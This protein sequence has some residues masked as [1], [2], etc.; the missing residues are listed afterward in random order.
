V[1]LP[2]VPPIKDSAE[3]VEKPVDTK[4]RPVVSASLGCHVVGAL[5]PH[6]DPADRETC[7]LGGKKRFLTKTPEPDDELLSELN[8]FVRKWLRE[9]LTPLASDSDTSV[10]NW[11]SH[12]NYPGWRKSQLLQKWQNVTSKFERK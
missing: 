2:E 6:P 10:D 11:L 7:I 12:T 3:I 5:M 4:E 9:N 1:D 8:A